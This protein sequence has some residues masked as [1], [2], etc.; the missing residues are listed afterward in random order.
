MEHVVSAIS[1]LAKQNDQFEQNEVESMNFFLEH[2]SELCFLVSQSF[3]DRQ[4]LIDYLSRLNSV[5]NL[6]I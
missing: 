3:E 1:A 6:E 5:T 2:C 4:N